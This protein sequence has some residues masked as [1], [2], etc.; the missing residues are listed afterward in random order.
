MW[1]C[2]RRCEGRG[3]RTG[4]YLC[5]AG[6]TEVQTWKESTVMHGWNGACKAYET[7]SRKRSDWMR[8]NAIKKRA[9]R[10]LCPH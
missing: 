1:D 5:A 6:F 8:E 4:K 10:K 7:K 2:D 9:K 3:L